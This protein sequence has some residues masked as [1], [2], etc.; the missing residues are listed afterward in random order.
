VDRV[1]DKEH[2]QSR[3]ISLDAGTCAFIIRSLRPILDAIKVELERD[4]LPEL[5]RV[6][7]HKKR[8]SI[9][10]LI[11]TLRGNKTAKER[12]KLDYRKGVLSERDIDLSEFLLVGEDV[13]G[14]L[15]LAETSCGEVAQEEGRLQEHGFLI[16][17]YRVVP[18]EGRQIDVF[19]PVVEDELVEW[20]QK[21]ADVKAYYAIAESKGSDGAD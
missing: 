4:D 12:G 16:T 15:I 3:T 5:L 6:T 9:D 2:I 10:M 20:V 13:D 21:D 1:V 18:E 11:H 8:L 14:D 19:W 7:L 17:R